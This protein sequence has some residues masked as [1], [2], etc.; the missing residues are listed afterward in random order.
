VAERSLTRSA[1]DP[2]QDWPLLLNAV[3]AIRAK[4]GT[5]AWLTIN[6]TRPPRSRQLRLKASYEADKSE[7]TLAELMAILET[8]IVQ[9]RRQFDSIHSEKVE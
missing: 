4:E 6:E 7:R 5:R 9:I 8:M 3:V 2:N 1:G